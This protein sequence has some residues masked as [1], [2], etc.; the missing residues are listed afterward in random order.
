MRHEY[1][2]LALTGGDDEASVQVKQT[3]E[4]DFLISTCTALWVDTSIFILKI[5]LSCTFLDVRLYLI[6]MKRSDA[7]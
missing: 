3:L 7:A 4:L 2:Q 1:F 6:F 5:G